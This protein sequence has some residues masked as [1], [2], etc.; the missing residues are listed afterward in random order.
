MEI[1]F[2]HGTS[3]PR[4]VDGKITRIAF[5]G[6]GEARFRLQ[7]TRD[8]DGTPDSLSWCDVSAMSNGRVDPLTMVDGLNVKDPRRTLGSV[9]GGTLVDRV[10]GELEV[11]YRRHIADWLRVI[12][13]DDNP[14]VT[15]LPEDAPERGY[16][17]TME[18]ANGSEP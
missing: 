13:Y 15:E 11:L 8:L 2:E 9:R 7:H 16:R 18:K 17:V 3:T 12:P 10:N 1:L 4:K 6:E 14:L 5:A